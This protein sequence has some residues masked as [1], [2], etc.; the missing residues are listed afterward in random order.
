MVDQISKGRLEIGFGR[1]ASPIEASYFG[2]DHAEA[3]E[4]YR[5][6]LELILG[7]FRDGSMD[8]RCTF[9]GHDTIPILVKPFQKPHPPLW[10]GA[11]STE[12]AERAAQMGSNIVSLDTAEETR[13]FANCFRTV[14]KE[15][16]AH[17]DNTPLVG[18]G[19]FI[20]VAE[21]DNT[22]LRIARRAYPVWHDS[23]NWL[24]RLHSAKLPRHQR[25]ADFDGMAAQGRAVA[26]SPATVAAIL[27]D[28]I[29]VSSANYLV[30]QHV[31]GDL[32]PEEATQSVELF[33]AH[34]MPLLQAQFPSPIHKSED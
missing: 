23:F 8:G 18:L 7:A 15:K 32:T 19:I 4:T 1:G 12:S 30:G 10:Y 6:S 16:Q 28:R 20:V 31:F 25:P 21:D 27:K 29:A 13:L 11:H 33:S 5:A 22:A 3:E 2:N 24:F 17:A 9:G 14:W 34:V 26:G